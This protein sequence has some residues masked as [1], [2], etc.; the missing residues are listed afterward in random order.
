VL[1]RPG[2]PE[3]LAK[4]ATDYSG[5]G[6]ESVI[7]NELCVAKTARKGL[8]ITQAPGGKLVANGHIPG[9]TKLNA[10]KIYGDILHLNQALPF[11]EIK[12]GLWLEKAETGPRGR[13]DHDATLGIDPNGRTVDYRQKQGAD[14]RETGALR[15]RAAMSDRRPGAS[16]QCEASSRMNHTC[17]GGLSPMKR[18]AGPPLQ[19]GLWRSGAD[20]DN[21]P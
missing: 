14:R 1:R 12:A 15:E 10:Y 7:F 21:P 3:L 16:H 17:F 8:G 6:Q 4:G 13:W 5:I 18:R 20:A 11:G 2:W 9:Y 19:A